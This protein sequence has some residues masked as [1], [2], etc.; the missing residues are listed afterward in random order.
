[1]ER[2]KCYC[3]RE[4]IFCEYASV[5]RECGDWKCAKTGK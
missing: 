5:D 3:Y 4:E 2:P 1:M